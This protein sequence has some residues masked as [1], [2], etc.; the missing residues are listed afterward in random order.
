M[1]RLSIC[2]RSRFF[3]TFLSMGFVL[4]ALS[5]LVPCPAAGKADYDV[6]VI[7]AGGGGLAAGA[8]LAR[9][10]MSVLLI[11]QHSKV[12]GYMSEFYRGDYTFEV[13]LHGMDGLDSGGLHATLLDRLGIVNAIAPV[14]LDPM[15]HAVYSDFELTVPADISAYLLI[16]TAQFSQAL[17]LFNV[18][19]FQLLL[20]YRNATLSDL[21]DAYV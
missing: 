12:G 7:G 18:Y 17:E 19:D 11:E 4:L 8:R 5:I 15:Y 16:L 6:V 1:P 2:P 9:A 3:C 10:G 21:L 14:R 20:A 13:S